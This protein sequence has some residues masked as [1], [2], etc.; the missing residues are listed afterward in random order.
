MR[1]GGLESAS[2]DR[3]VDVGVQFE[4]AFWTIFIGIP[5][6]EYPM[7]AFKGT[8]RHYEG[9]DLYMLVD[10]TGNMAEQKMVAWTG[11]VLTRTIGDNL[12]LTIEAAV[13]IEQGWEVSEN[14]EVMFD[15]WAIIEENDEDDDSEND[16]HDG[17]PIPS[18]VAEADLDD[19]F[20]VA[21]VP[22]I[23]VPQPQRNENRPKPVAYLTNRQLPFGMRNE[24]DIAYHLLE[25]PFL[26]DYKI[27]DFVLQ[28]NHAF[29]LHSTDLEFTPYHYY[30]QE[31]IDQ[32]LDFVTETQRNVIQSIRS[33]VITTTQG[34][35]GTGKSSC[36]AIGIL[37][38][39]LQEDGTIIVCCPSNFA[40]HM[41]YEKLKAY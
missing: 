24:Q 41:I 17:R 33:N 40:A 5:L 25:R 16:E 12:H 23:V 2:Y 28:R 8:L 21:A 31:I 11:R 38:L 27:L 18:A 3:N 37:A 26:I 30:N 14:V 39:Y 13:I 10:P 15:T 6:L 4:Q 22:D 7:F 29:M 34:P 20:A 36:A 9:L 1:R 35:P 19:V 32:L